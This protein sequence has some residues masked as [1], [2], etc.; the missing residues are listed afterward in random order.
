MSKMAGTKDV[1]AIFDSFI[2]SF[3][4]S[5][6]YIGVGV[7]AGRVGRVVEKTKE[8]MKLFTVSQNVQKT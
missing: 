2:C 6:P 7:W 5:A 3:I 8:A 4:T 1:P